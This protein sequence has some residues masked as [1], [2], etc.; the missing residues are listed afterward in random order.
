MVELLESDSSLLVQSKKNPDLDSDDSENESENNLCPHVFHIN[1]FLTF[2]QKTYIK[3][4]MG[5]NHP[6]LLKPAIQCCICKRLVLWENKGTHAF[7]PEQYPVYGIHKFVDFWYDGK[8]ICE[9]WIT[10]PYLFMGLQKTLKFPKTKNLVLPRCYTNVNDASSL[11][12]KIMQTK[13]NNYLDKA[14]PKQKCVRC[15]VKFGMYQLFAHMPFSSEYPP[16]N[17]RMCQ[18]CFLKE[19]RKGTNREDKSEYHLFCP[20]CN[21]KMTFYSLLGESA[22]DYFANK[23]NRRKGK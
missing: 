22:K 18:E 20:N 11:N 13:V 21:R 10:C 9:N 14:I 5:S 23:N 19:I 3:A 12:K 2:V 6:H 16:C 17:Y 15:S 1:C 4:K 7:M 8:I